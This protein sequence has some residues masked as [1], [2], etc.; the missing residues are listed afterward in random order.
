[1]ISLKIKKI[2][3]ARNNQSNNVLVASDI[4]HHCASFNPHQS[5][6][7]RQAT[8]PPSPSLSVHTPFKVSSFLFPLLSAHTLECAFGLTITSLTV[9]AG[10][11]FR[12]ANNNFFSSFSVIQDRR[13]KIY[14]DP[15]L[16]HRPC[17]RHSYDLNSLRWA[18][19][20]MSLQGRVQP[21]LWT[22]FLT[23][24]RLGLF[25]YQQLLNTQV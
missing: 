25:Q 1:M 19:L 14:N 3:L 8:T 5:E 7:S 9:R 21:V 22:L 2:S 11:F 24:A 10:F 17:R 23:A 18:W 15:L 16:C 12:L 20:R 13:T 6:P 4:K